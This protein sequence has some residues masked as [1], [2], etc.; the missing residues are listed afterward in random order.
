MKAEHSRRIA[1]R[2]LAGEF[3]GRIPGR[4]ASTYGPR[5]CQHA[6]PA[7]SLAGENPSARG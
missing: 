3:T 2:E 1:S 6:R 4:R 7:Q 5:R